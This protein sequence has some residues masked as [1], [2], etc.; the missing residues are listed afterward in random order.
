MKRKRQQRRVILIIID[1]LNPRALEGAISRGLMP[2]MEFLR[3]R[4]FF[5]DSCVSVFPTMTPTC[6]A[7]I[8]TG[9]MPS[10]HQIPGFV[11]FNRDENRIVN[12]GVSFTAVFKTGVYRVVQ[13]LLFNLNRYQLSR[14]VRTLYE[15]IEGAGLLTAAVN[16]FIYRSGYKHQP[17][18][19]WLMQ[20]AALFRLKGS[21]AGPRHLFLGNMCPAP[22]LW[23]NL[24]TVPGF[25]NKFGV[26]DNYSG[27]V[28]SWLISSGKQPDF[29]SV[30]LPDTD[31]YAHRNHPEEMDTS[32]QKADLQLQRIL[33]SFT[34]WD[35]AVRDNMFIIVG[36]HSQS[37]VLSA[38]NGLINLDTLLN[39]FTS[40][41]LGEL[42]GRSK[43]LALCPNERMAHL[44]ILKQ[45]KQ[46][47]PRL[48]ELLAS[49]SR[50]DQVVWKEGACYQVRRGGE[51]G[52]LRFWAGGELSDIYGAKWR[53]EGNPNLVGAQRKGQTLYF[54][55]YPDAFSRLAGCLSAK[56]AGD[57]IITARPG[58]EFVG[59]GAPEHPGC[60]SHG[61]LHRDDSLVP[62]VVTGVDAKLNSPR[63]TDLYPLILAEFKIR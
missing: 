16:P 45:D 43:E 27:R 13:D 58:Y 63:L 31:G 38:S 10:D 59:E 60:G 54:D 8:V 61:S 40:I 28:A 26:N 52:C 23:S 49:D 50:I 11:W 2:A 48:V 6:A 37:L 30:Y 1:S 14:R 35:Q 62:L 18:I 51:S 17:Q 29:L 56:H 25:L 47:L 21:L 22:D 4:G 5:T 44:Y 46:V 41:S 36:D 33:N 24:T 57:I 15:V 39:G 32:L 9:T 55:Q 7:S 53:I 42:N 19:P 20:L 3:G 12:Y 34:S